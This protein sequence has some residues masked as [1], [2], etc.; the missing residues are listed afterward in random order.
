MRVGVRVVRSCPPD[1]MKTQEG[2]PCPGGRLYKTL[3]V[4]TNRLVN[5]GDK[6]DAS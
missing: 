4:G 3:F 5:L 1:I 6:E 2:Q